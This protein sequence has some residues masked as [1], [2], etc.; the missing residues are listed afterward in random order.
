[1]VKYSIKLGALSVFIFL[2]AIGGCSKRDKQT[3]L[4]KKSFTIKGSDTMVHL[5]STL[6]E[7]YMKK[8]SGMQVSVTG[9]GSGTGIAALI[10]GTTDICASS[11]DMQQKEKD[12]AKSKNINPV[13]KIIAYDGI[14]VIVNPDNPIKEMTVDQIKKI[15]T[16]VTKSWKDLGG[17]DETIT[18][19]SRESNSGTY[20]FFQEHVLNKENYA[21]TV[22][23]MPASSAIVQSVSSDK[24]SIGYVGLGYTKDAKVKIILVK[25]DDKAP[26]IAPS[27]STVLD[28]TYGIARPLY[29]YFNG[30]PEGSLKSFLDYAISDEGQKIVDETG[31]V[32]LK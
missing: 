2:L 5:M 10:N 6:A 12:D 23:L 24:W 3:S 26:A 4:N 25:K 27:H 18:I 15:Y 31:Y 22:K 17:P 30:E 8:N 21:P 11:R 29:L 13:E 9:G 32:T 19:L 20:V 7:A 28:K 1:M 16:G 14:A